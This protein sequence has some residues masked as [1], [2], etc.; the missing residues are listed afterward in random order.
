MPRSYHFDMRCV[1][2][3]VLVAI[4]ACGPSAA[5]IKTARS[6]SYTGTPAEIFDG[7]MAAVSDTYQIGDAK[8][9]GDQYALVTVP[10]WYNAE[11]GRESAGAGDV[12]QVR[13][14]S[15]QVRF[16]VELVSTDASHFVV[17]VTPK[18]FQVVSGSPQPRELTPDDPNLPGW[19]VGRVDTLHLAIHKRLQNYTVQ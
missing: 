12:V 16:V 5:E 1:M 14:G 11:G 10:Q 4:V 15:V 2:S 19:V 9:D 6:A 7:V 3:L 8:R 18:T 13:G 17:T